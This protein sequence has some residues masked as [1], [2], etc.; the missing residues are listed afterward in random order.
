MTKFTFVLV[1][2]VAL[3]NIQLNV[4]ASSEGEGDS[5]RELLR[6]ILDDARNYASRQLNAMKMST[7]PKTDMF[8]KRVTEI[9]KKA[10]TKRDDLEKIYGD[11]N[12]DICKKDKVKDD[13]DNSALTTIGQYQT[14][15]IN[16]INT[17]DEDMDSMSV[18]WVLLHK[19]VSTAK[20]IDEELRRKVNEFSARSR[21]FIQ[22][23]HKVDACNAQSTLPQL[24]QRVS[25]VVASYTQCLKKNQ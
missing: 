3:A 7:Q 5:S 1:G 14:C 20:N 2:L 12:I 11:A 22:Y 6:M 13:I 17:A 8:I 21:Q 10:L 18:D 25:E 9:E 24:E 19:E 16:V 4:A 23:T 15:V